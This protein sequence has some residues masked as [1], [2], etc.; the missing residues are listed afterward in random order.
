M[1]RKLLATTAIVALMSGGVYAADNA[2]QADTNATNNSMIFSAEPGNPMESQNGYFEAMPGQ[3]LASNLIGQS[4]YASASSDA[5]RVGE[6]NDVLLSQ[7]GNAEAVVI[8]VGGFLG[9]GEKDVA[10]DF[11]R[12][13]WVERDGDRWLTAE[14]TKEELDQAP[15]FNRADIM[16][17]HD[18]AADTTMKSGTDMAA[19]DQPT[20]DA[21]AKQDMAATEKPADD[22]A[23]KQDMAE[24]TTED[25]TSQEV[26]KADEPVTDN[27][28]T[29]SVRDGMVA[30]ESG[31]I[32]AENLLGA[33]V[34]GTDN[35][36]LGEVGDV[37]V[38]AEGDLDA[39]VIDV[40][41]F[42]GL[43]EKPVAL[44]GR[45]IEIMRDQSGFL[46]VYTDFTEEQ[47]K[48][49]PAYS[50]DAYE[51]DRDGVVLR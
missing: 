45:D 8:G 13:S 49:Q 4:V 12:L 29:A 46:Y 3:I 32:S 27:E 31:T 17:R 25:A 33:R 15:A 6:V 1:I 36:D 26:A 2:T 44:D 16:E 19:T 43:G 40:G 42:L 22:A 24:S 34:Y 20:D 41:G 39:Y 28:R 48:N 30:V 50:E 11:E 21:A 9:I 14:L 47:L 51:T 10:I 18:Q 23:V 35:E 38:T 5:E 37:L 7:N